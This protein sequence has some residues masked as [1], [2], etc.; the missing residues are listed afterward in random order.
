MFFV[1]VLAVRFA[2][3]FDEKGGIETLVAD[4]TGEAGFVIRL[5]GRT[6][7]LFGKIYRGVAARTLGRCWNGEAWH[8]WVK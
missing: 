6:N 8:A 4:D 1:A 2:I 3:M 5:G 7:D